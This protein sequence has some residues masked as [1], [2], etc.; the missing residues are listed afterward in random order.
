MGTSQSSKGPGPGVP[1]V[2][3]WVPPVPPNDSKPDPNAPPDGAPP[4][5]DG[6]G[7]D[8]PTPT[9]LAAPA[10]F[11]SAKLSLGKFAK[12]GEKRFLRKGV[13]EY[14]RKGYA[15]NT[16]AAK[17]FAGTARTA[18]SLYDALSAL[19]SGQ[20]TERPTQLDKALLQGK[21]A[22]EIID[23]VIEAVRPVDGTQ[24]AEASREAINDSL[25][26]LLE[27][28]PDADLLT[29]TED[30]LALV[31]E[32]FTAED[33]FRRLLLDLGKHVHDKAPT[34]ANALARLK[35]IREYVRE[36]VAA[37]FRKIQKSGQQLNTGHVASVVRS[38]LADAMEVFELTRV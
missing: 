16:T 30:Q 25:S 7:P 1:L 2:P 3:P 4:D 35:E 33:I 21:S 36:V 22:R 38:T 11:G 28:F 13:S 14:V 10:R 29:L 26:D 12:S 24:D 23:S 19:S 6:A 9:P 20:T 18:G 5:N 34:V 17:R 31:V 37:S 27:A 15:G 32:S 8:S